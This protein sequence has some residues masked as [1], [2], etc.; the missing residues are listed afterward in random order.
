MHREK[1][2]KDCALFWRKAPII[3]PPRSLDSVG[4]TF[5]NL[6][7]DTNVGC[8]RLR[9]QIFCPDF[10]RNPNLSVFFNRTGEVWTLR[11]W[12]YGFGENGAGR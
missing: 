10:F 6:D 7:V 8:L 5:V 12:A 2:G 11:F 1:G 4:F 3:L 9:F